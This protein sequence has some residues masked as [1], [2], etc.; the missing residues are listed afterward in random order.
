MKSHLTFSLLLVFLFS[1]FACKKEASNENG[2]GTN[3][4][5]GDFYA[6]IDGNQWNADSIQLILVSSAGISIT[7]IS[8]TGE[9][10]SIELPEFKTG[11]YTLGSQSLSYALCGNLLTNVSNV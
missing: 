2:N 6:T 11:T 5:N 8:K 1:F 7:G 9:Q 10:I 3:P 4:Q